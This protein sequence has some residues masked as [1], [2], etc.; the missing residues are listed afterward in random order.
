MVFRH[1]WRIGKKPLVI[2]LAIVSLVWLFSGCG[3]M[4]LVYLNEPE[5]IVTGD[6]KVPSEFDGMWSLGVL[7]RVA[8]YIVKGEVTS[9]RCDLD[10]ETG[11]I[12]TDV[13]IYPFEF[14]KGDISDIITVRVLGGQ[15]GS[16]VLAVTHEPRFRVGEQVVVFLS[17]HPSEECPLQGY[18]G[19]VGGLKGK[20]T[21]FNGRVLEMDLDEHDLLARIQAALNGEEIGP[22]PY[23]TPLSYAP[24]DVTSSE[25]AP[26]SYSYTEW[27]WPSSYPR[28]SYY[29]NTNATPRTA[30]LKAIKAAANA[31]NKAGARF[32]LVY[33]G[34]TTRYSG[35]NDSI[36]VVEF[37]RSFG[38][39]GWPARTLIWAINRGSYYDIVECDMQ[40]NAYYQWAI[41]SMNNRFDLQNVVTHEFGHFVSLNDLYR[42]RE[43]NM[44]M[45]GYV[46]FGETKK[47]SLAGPDK[48]GV[49][50]IYGRRK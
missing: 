10:N 38:N 6:E 23:F 48:L 26:L 11:L 40:I 47:R 13:E 43:K 18:L 19:V 16:L 15:V 35:Y 22:D 46:A 42:R 9:I 1:L 41:G 8:E 28:I 4:D 33:G 5:V 39:T 30:V 7:S 37:R 34:A 50:Q 36:N 20:L 25:V 17:P 12:Y 3:L 44:T 49:R 24:K 31:W 45:Y 2:L 21:L 29:I 14:I 27:R 32:E